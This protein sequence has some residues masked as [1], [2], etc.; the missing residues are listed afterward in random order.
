MHAIDNDKTEPSATPSTSHSTGNNVGELLFFPRFFSRALEVYLWLLAG[1]VVSGRAYM[2]LKYA[3]P[4]DEKYLFRDLYWDIVLAVAV[5]ALPFVFKLIF[6]ALPFEYIRLRRFSL[7]PIQSTINIVTD[8]TPKVQDHSTESRQ[9]PPAEQLRLLFSYA[10]ESRQLA[11]GIYSRAGVYLLVGV[12]VAFFGLAFF[13]AQTP[14]IST[15]S[16][17]HP[18]WV[19]L[20][21][22][23]GILFFIEFVAFFFLRQYRTAM[24]EFRYY[25]GIA[26]AREEVLGLLHTSTSLGK[27][28]SPM[29]L[30][31]YDAYFSRAGT[32]AKGQTTEI[33]ESRKIEGG[34]ELDL[35]QKVVDIL[36]KSKK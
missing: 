33:L 14:V 32:L 4:E 5:V 29:E 25:E 20:A 13:Y 19:T 34:G 3:T 28:V 27:S 12:V 15:K 10:S 11:K 22:N 26:R 31:K 8:S 1:A 21:P 35:L 17:L 16:E 36:S 2:V 7:P 23:F 30:V 24:D 6:G 18:F 9:E